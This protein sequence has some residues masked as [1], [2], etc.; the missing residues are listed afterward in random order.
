LGTPLNAIRPEGTYL[1]PRGLVHEFGLQDRIAG[2]RRAN[3]V[4]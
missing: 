2:K 3:N 1:S 4:R